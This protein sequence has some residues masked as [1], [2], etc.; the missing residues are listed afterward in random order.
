MFWAINRITNERVNS[1]A[2]DF[3]DKFFKEEEWL[4]D[5]LMIKYCS[6]TVDITKITVGFR[7]ESKKIISDKGNLYVRRAHFYI[8]NSEKLGIQTK[9]EQKEHT[10]AINL[11]YN[12]LKDK[13]LSIEISETNKPVKHK[14]LIMLN[15]SEVDWNKIDIEVTI[16]NITTKRADVLLPLKE[17]NSLIGFGIVIEIQL[18]EQSN[19]LQLTRSFERA[20]KGYSIC[21]L[22]R[23]DFYDITSEDLKLKEDIIKIESFN[24][25]LKLYAEK[26]IDKIKEMTI[27]YSMMIDEKKE[28]MEKLKSYMQKLTEEIK[29]PVIQCP[30]CGGLLTIK[31]GQYGKFYGCSNW[32]P[33]KLGCNYNIPLRG[34]NNG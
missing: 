26:T 10:Q 24:L 4:A 2:A 19:S 25:I 5:P 8:P 11:V 7:K 1:I 9:P 32:K 6:P 23:D 3:S 33:D 30:K 12:L 20:N 34:N 21:W 18:T 15:K 31:N 17:Y 29:Y 27:N 22:K 14:N 13:K 28:D 16:N